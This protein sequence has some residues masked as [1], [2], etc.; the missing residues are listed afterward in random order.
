MDNAIEKRLVDDGT[1]TAMLAQYLSDPAIFITV[2]LPQGVVP[3]YVAVPPAPVLLPHDT[4][5]SVG[6][7]VEREIGCY[8]RASGDPSI[9]D[10]IANR[11]WE[12]FHRHPL[13][14]EGWKNI[15]VNA[16][17]PVIAPTDKTLYGRIVPISFTIWKSPSS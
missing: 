7:V 1:L 15:I 12:L 5:I 16:S 6:R 17:G 3:P 14:V 2:P 8:T 13:E 10:S 11:V 9:V 4:K